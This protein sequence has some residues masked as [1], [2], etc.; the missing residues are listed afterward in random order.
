MTESNL[1]GKRSMNIERKKN[2]GFRENWQLKV[3]DR[4]RR[5][6][7]PK[8]GR[9]MCICSKRNKEVAEGKKILRPSFITMSVVAPLHASL[10]RSDDSQFDARNF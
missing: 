10:V 4:R 1:K 9:K 8:P 6:L 2:A 3:Y 7:R 5:G